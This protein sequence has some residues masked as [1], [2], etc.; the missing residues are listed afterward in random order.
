VRHYFVIIYLVIILVFGWN[1]E[2]KALN[3]SEKQI[4]PTEQEIS[5]IYF[6]T[7]ANSDVHNIALNEVTYLSTVIRST[8]SFQKFPFSEAFTEKKIEKCLKDKISD[9]LFITECRTI[10]LE[11]PDIIHP[12]DYFW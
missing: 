6:F 1:P 10:R 7:P 11:D 3:K 8:E 12:F 4:N 5:N 2:G 9:Y